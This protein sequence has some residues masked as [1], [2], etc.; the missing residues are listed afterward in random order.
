MC[1]LFLRKTKLCTL[2]NM[3]NKQN[4]LSVGLFLDL[5]KAFDTIDHKMLL[6]K[7]E[8]YGVRGLPLH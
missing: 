6:H 3:V 4:T 5:S 7:L 8:F 1:I 2:V